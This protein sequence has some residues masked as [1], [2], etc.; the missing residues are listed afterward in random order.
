[1][2]SQHA[3]HSYLFQPLPGQFHDAIS[4]RQ[5]DEP[6]RRGVRGQRRWQTVVPPPQHHSHRYGDD[7]GHGQNDEPG[8]PVRRDRVDEQAEDS[9][10]ATGEHREGLHQPARVVK[11]VLLRATPNAIQQPHLVS[12]WASYGTP[13]RTCV[14]EVVGGQASPKFQTCPLEDRKPTPDLSGGAHDVLIGALNHYL[15]AEQDENHTP[16]VLDGR[17][18]LAVRACSLRRW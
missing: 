18:E 9:D 5:C 1:M 17:R 3:L 15:V 8:D 12:R 16:Q 6:E 4:A 7:P 13:G 14:V 11:R 2:T 10:H